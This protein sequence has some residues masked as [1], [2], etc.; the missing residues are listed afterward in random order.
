[1]AGLAGIVAAGG[2]L[3]GFQL[4]PAITHRE[5][6]AYV[7]QVLGQLVPDPGVMI[8]DSTT[9]GSVSGVLSHRQ[10]AIALG[11]DTS[12]FDQPASRLVRFDDRGRL[13]AATLSVRTIVKKGPAADCG[14]AVLPGKRWLFEVPPAAAPGWVLRAGVLT[15]VAGTLTVEI[16]GTAR[17]IDVAQGW[18]DAWFPALHPY[19]DIFASFESMDGNA[20]AG[21]C[22]TDIELGTP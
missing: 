11:Q 13:V 7:R 19:G 20:A 14:W 4:M 18:S 22:I 9:P 10:L 16:N 6:G 12:G 1:V 5:G 8:A 2:I 3:M 21:A 17:S 15:G